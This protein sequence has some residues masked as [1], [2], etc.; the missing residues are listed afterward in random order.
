MT[1]IVVLDVETTGKVRERDQIIEVCVQLG[2]DAG[3]ESHVWRVRPTVPIAP[4]AQA[5]HGITA[6]DLESCPPF[7]AVAPRLVLLL[8]AADVIVGYNVGFDLDMVQA[9]LAR[10]HMAP[11]DL[12]FKQ[13]VDVLRLWHHVE[14]RTLAAAHEKF[15][16]RPIVDAH[17]AAADVAAT[18]NVLVA[19]LDRFELAGRAWHELAAMANPFTGREKWIGPS[20]H[21][22]WEGDV[23]VF[24]FGKNR[25]ARIDQV[26]AGFLNWVIRMDFPAHVKDVC[27]HALGLRGEALHAWIAQ[28]F[29]R[30]VRTD[31]ALAAGGAA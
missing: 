22:Q 9:E 25:G 30:P 26:D 18:G 1:R 29:P 10:A 4:D 8:D 20:H 19:M 11:L 16:G 21:L 24:A 28:R 27:R 2:L 17:A 5:V 6:A 15:V 14:P 31:D 12:A 23:A 13:V 7:A 3:A